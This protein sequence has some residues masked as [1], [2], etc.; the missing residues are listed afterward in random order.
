ML[1]IAAVIVLGG[2]AATTGLGGGVTVDGD[3]H[4]GLATEIHGGPV[5]SEKVTAVNDDNAP[6]AANMWIFGVELEVEA[7]HARPRAAFALTYYVEYL[8]LG[9]AGSPWGYHA[10][11]AVGLGARG[12]ATIPLSVL[13]GPNH[14]SSQYIADTNDGLIPHA[15]T[16]GLDVSASYLVN[17]SCWFRRNACLA[18]PSPWEF[19]AF[20]ARQWSTYDPEVGQF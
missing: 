10:R 20:Y 12:G 3:G 17:A 5:G 1:R 4:V 18:T 9:T 8:H 14:L 6:L 15:I 11:L 13:V 2:C 7:R 19:A 16:S